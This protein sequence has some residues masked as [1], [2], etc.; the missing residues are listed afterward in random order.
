MN[1]FVRLLSALRK[2]VLA[3]LAAGLLGGAAWG[4]WHRQASGSRGFSF[5]TDKAVQGNLTA[6]VN[7]TG[8]V[9]PE[10][11]IDV[12]AQVAGQIKEFGRDLDGSRKTIDYR[13]RVEE[14]TVLAKIDDALF[15]PDVDAARADLALAEAEVHRS[16]CDVDSARAKLYQTE[17]DYERARRLRSS[18][19]L[20]PV[21][22]DTAQNLYLTAK[23]AAP[24]AEAIL[25]K[26]QRA[27]DQK[28]EA[29]KKA[30]KNLSFCTI[31]SPVR[32]VIIDRR[33]NIGQT[34]V[35]S[36]NAPSLFLIAKDLRRMQVWASVNEA[37][38]GAVHR[39]QAVTFTADARPGEV[40]TGQVYQV[41]YNANSTQNVVT[42]TVVVNTENV[43]DDKDPESYKLLPY[44]TANLQ[45]QIDERTDALLVPN[46]A[47]RWSP[48]LPMV[49]GEY[50]PGFEQ[51]ARQKALRDEGK[52]N[53]AAADR[54]ARGTVWF[55]EGGF[56]KPVRVRTGPTDGSMTEV[57][58]VLEGALTAGT[59]LV[60]GIN[61]PR[62]GGNVNPF[63]A[64]KVFGNKSQ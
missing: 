48:K 24:A 42:Y 15:A 38:V 63:F 20:A 43:P 4:V 45:F 17:R 23:A 37:D 52:G 9:V 51:A 36:L 11:V 35:S 56:V 12:G 46:A 22:Y 55:E 16:Q 62:P 34:V 8:T 49:A 40:F 47:L 13:S 33:V 7:A 50:R 21:D 3:C 29:L 28:R 60:T 57:V 31:R 30:E 61:Q 41:R 27:V 2:V 58:A 10:E 25:L 6:T 54:H 5:R 1:S 18:G 64:P 14:G 53:Q 59:P 26:A 19:M 44:L 32:G 39:G